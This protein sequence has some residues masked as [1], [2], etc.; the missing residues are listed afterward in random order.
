MDL[1]VFDVHVPAASQQ[2]IQV[3]Y[4]DEQSD[5]DV[6]DKDE[7]EDAKRAKD[8]FLETLANQTNIPIVMQTSTISSYSGSDSDSDS[9]DGKT[10]DY[11][12]KKT[13]LIEML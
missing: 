11:M 9:A 7:D 1:G 13:P 3:I 6:R 8:S 12:G 5:A 2:D 10:V 4:K